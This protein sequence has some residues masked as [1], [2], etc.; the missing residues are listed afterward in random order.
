MCMWHLHSRIKLKEMHE[1]NHLPYS[2]WYRH[3][4]RGKGKSD[5]HKRLDAEKQ[6]SVPTVS[7]D[8]CFTGQ[9][10]NYKILPIIG[11]CDHH[12]KMTYSHIVVAKAK[13]IPTQ[14]G[15]WCMILTSLVVAIVF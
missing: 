6:H 11:I 10:D 5:S 3:C 4:V 8:Y 7:M 13:N 12:H 9:D 14:L 2:S 15:K 1:A